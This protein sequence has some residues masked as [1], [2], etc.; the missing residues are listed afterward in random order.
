MKNA[1]YPEAWF[2]GFPDGRKPMPGQVVSFPILTNGKKWKPDVSPG[3]FRVLYLPDTGV[4]AAL[5]YHIY[6]TPGRLTEWACIDFNEHASFASYPASPS[7][8]SSSPSPSASHPDHPP[9]PSGYH[10]PPIPSH[11]L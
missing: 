9:S 1:R 6:N 11:L 10:P 7:S 3:P 8:S 2:Q 4:Y 5:I